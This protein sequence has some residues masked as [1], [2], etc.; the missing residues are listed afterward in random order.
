MNTTVVAIGHNRLEL[1]KS[2]LQGAYQRIEAGGNEWVEGSL[3]F[4]A[5]LLEGR[6][7]VPADTG[8]K[9]WLEKNNL[10]FFN[11]QD[12]AALLNLAQNPDLARGILSKTES[13]SY[14]LIWD[15]NKKRFQSATG[16]F[17]SAGKPP[18]DGKLKRTRTIR[19][20]VSRN[21]RAM[22]LGAETIRSLEGTS[23]ASAEEQRELVVLNRGAPAG[24]KTEVVKDLVARATA[25]EMVSAIAVGAA[26]SGRAAPATNKLIDM[27]SRRMNFIWLQATYK[28]RESFIEF[29]MNDHSKKGDGNS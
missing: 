3:E 25:G 21:N 23:L 17:T 28:T 2:K 20:K 11:H 12:R 10:D 7:L 16:R 19:T 29:L 9:Q 18:A 26:M 13:R 22:K 4:A 6:E 24:E 14:R 15:Q 8:F 1:L 5:A 27:F